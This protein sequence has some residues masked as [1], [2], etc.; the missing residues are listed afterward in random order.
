[1]KL[2]RILKRARVRIKHRKPWTEPSYNPNPDVILM[3]EPRP[4]DNLDE[5]R[6]TLIH[7]V[8][9]ATGH[10]AWIDRWTTGRAE[11][12]RTEPG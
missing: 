3:P 7:E 1:M 10:P 6:Q 5:Y 4:F 2:D 9:H 11:T 12:R 8:V